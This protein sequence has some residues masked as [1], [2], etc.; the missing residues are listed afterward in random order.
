MRASYRNFLHKLRGQL[1]GR[2]AKLP[3]DDRRAILDDRLDGDHRLAT[4]TARVRTRAWT[5][6]D[7]EI[8]E[9]KASGFEE[10]EIFEAAICAAVSAGE[11][12]FLTVMKHLGGPPDAS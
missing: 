2:D 5:M 4:F 3:V 9:L 7:G 10:D 11:Q 12:R 1:L 6:T 8:D